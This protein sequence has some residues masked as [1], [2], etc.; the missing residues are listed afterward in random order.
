MQKYLQRS[1]LTILYNDEEFDQTK[2]GDGA[3][4]RTSKL[5]I[6]QI[7][8]Y[9]PQAYNLSLQENILEDDTAY[10]QIE[11]PGEIFFTSLKVD[12][13]VVVSTW[14]NFPTPDDPKALYK[15][16]SFSL[17]RNYDVALVT[18]E[19]YGL[20]DCLG[21]VGGLYDALQ[22]IAEVLLIPLTNYAYQSL[23]LN[24]IFHRKID[25]KDLKIKQKD[26][27]LSQ[28]KNIELDS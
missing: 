23:L 13:P 1:Q 11:E 14:T 16:L 12:K 17:D 9:Q 7:D 15:F 18:R 6:K 24:N 26:V 21:D 8:A 4:K 20:L 5:F 2:Y 25:K 27:K 22:L 19:T 10:V 3:I 28:V